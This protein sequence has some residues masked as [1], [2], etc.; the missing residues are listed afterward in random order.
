MSKDI[1]IKKPARKCNT[2]CKNNFNFNSE[3]HLTIKNF[4]FGN[5]VSLNVL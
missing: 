2:A 1:A 4:S 3:V 5:K